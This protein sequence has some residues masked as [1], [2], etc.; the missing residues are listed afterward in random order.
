MTGQTSDTQYWVA[1]SRIPG[2]G[3][4]RYQLLEKHFGRLENAWSAAAGELRAAGLDERTTAAIVAQR[5]NISP[6]AEMERLARQGVRAI[7]WN[8]DAY[9]PR[10]KEI[11][12]LPPVLYIRGELTDADEWS[13]AVVGTRRPTAYG[14]QV[15]EHLASDLAVQ[16]ITIVSCPASAWAC[17]WW[18]AT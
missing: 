14:R 11:F 13:V 10:L 1:F 15:A 6:E 4:V 2:I 16:G 18:R 9:P 5:P 17:W 3:R 12:D 8:D 7:T